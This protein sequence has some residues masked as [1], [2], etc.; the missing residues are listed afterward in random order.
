MSCL[1]TS[2]CR[3]ENVSA[4]AETSLIEYMHTS[5]PITYMYIYIYIYA[6][7]LG[8]VMETALDTILES[9]GGVKKLVDAET[10]FFA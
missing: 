8:L 2:V 5:T 4:Y 1:Y 3:C 9:V 7:L 10:S 6:Y